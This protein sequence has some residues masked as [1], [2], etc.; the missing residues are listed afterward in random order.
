MFYC[1]SKRVVSTAISFSYSIENI[2]NLVESNSG[3]WL[4]GRTLFYPWVH[5]RL[6][7]WIQAF[8]CIILILSIIWTNNSFITLSTYKICHGVFVVPSV[9]PFFNRSFVRLLHKKISTPEYTDLNAAKMAEGEINSSRWPE[10]GVCPKYVH[11]WRML[12]QS[13]SVWCQAI[14]GAAVWTDTIKDNQRSFP[15]KI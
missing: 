3:I 1:F 10:Y 15:I 8:W 13:T 7:K 4:I 9:R 2:W 11:D 6:Q 5:E 14:H 12:R